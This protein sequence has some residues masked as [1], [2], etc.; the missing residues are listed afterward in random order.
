MTLT[1]RP[2]R[3]HNLHHSPTRRPWPSPSSHTEATTFTTCLREGH[4]LHHPITQATT[5]T[6]CLREGHDLHHP[7]TQRPQP[8]P[9]AQTKAMTFTIRSHRGHNLHHLPT[10][11]P[12]PLP[13]EHTGHNHH[14]LPTR[15]PWPS[16]SGHTEATTF[17][18]RLHKDH[19]I[20]HAVTKKQ[21][22]YSSATQKQWT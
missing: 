11:R 19:D 8:S 22:I 6:T 21:Q 13:S 1:I 5:F 4:D 16:P 10:R 9:L 14:H 7:A 15:R 17:N 18:T 12:W 2:H 3:G 20:H